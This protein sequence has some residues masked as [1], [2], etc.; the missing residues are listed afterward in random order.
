MSRANSVAFGKRD[1]MLNTECNGGRQ[2]AGFIADDGKLWFPTMGGVVVIDPEA[3]SVNPLAPPVV[4]ESVTLERGLID[5][6]FQP[7][8][9]TVAPG[10]RDLEIN[11]TGLSLLK[12]EQVKFKYRLEGLDADWVDV[13]TRRVVYFPYL[14]PGNYTFRVIAANSD[15]VWNNEG[16]ELSIVLKHSRATEALLA[17]LREEEF[18]TLTIR[19]NGVGFAAIQGEARHAGSGERKAADDS[20]SRPAHAGGFGMIGMAERVRMLGG[21]FS[22]ES[23]PNQG[24][25]ITIK[26]PVQ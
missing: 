6:S 7:G 24:T 13:G 17:V 23:A 16:A 15:G 3:A 20:D 21:V 11:Y 2:S 14:P 12:S 22:L 1:G 8:G 10:Q 9:V 18:I 25:A 5:F 19:D 4:I 26:F